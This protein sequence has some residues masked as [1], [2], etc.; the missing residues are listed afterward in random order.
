M[1]FVSRIQVSAA[2]ERK[3]AGEGHRS[4]KPAQTG[5]PLAFK[6]WACVPL[7][8]LCPRVMISQN[9][10]VPIT[11]LCSCRVGHT[12]VRSVVITAVFVMTQCVA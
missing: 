6:N 2:K 4:S 1:I 12:R 7:Y 11:V 8:W 3:Q 10:I 5:L 9:V